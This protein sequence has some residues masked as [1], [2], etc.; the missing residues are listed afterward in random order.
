MMFK[1]SK[2]L[3]VGGSGSWGQELTRQLLLR[4]PKQII[5]F[6]RGEILQ[7][8]MQRKFN[9]NLVK[10]V[11]GDV[12]DQRAVDDIVPGVDYIF[13][14]AALKHVPT[15]ENQVFEAIQTNI[16][17]ANNV[18]EAAIK[19]KVK[20]FID[21]STDKAVDPIN[22][23]GL[24]KAIGEKLTIQANCQTQDTEFICIRSGNVLGTN[25]SVVPFIIDQI[26]TTN[27]AKVMDDRMTRFFITF[28]QAI[29]LLLYATE[30]G[31]GG[32][33]YV[34]NMPS[35]YIKDLVEL[36]ADHYG[37][38]NTK[39]EILGAREGEKTNEVLISPHEI[40]RTRYV[41]DDYFVIYPQLKTGRVYSDIYMKPDIPA[42]GFSSAD[43]L[44]DKK[45]LRKLLKEGGYL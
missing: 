27:T 35:F 44:K 21:I 28:E 16:L 12:R 5:I 30:T 1:D 6:S 13:H 37:N 36:L 26:R 2:I 42:H 34:M 3:C 4:G 19:Y 8:S 24:T 41:N 10:Y 23:Y 22:L 11:I 20:K 40:Y 15:C 29:K 14:L 38:K 33:T 32:E 17:G 25:G 39:I 31:M 9:N 43:N 7:I 45:Y 18:I